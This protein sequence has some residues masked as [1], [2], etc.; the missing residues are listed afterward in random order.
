MIL[1]GSSSGLFG[2]LL[3]CP[4]YSS[5]VNVC[6]V[7]TNG[8]SNNEEL[9]NKPGLYYSLGHTMENKNVEFPIGQV[10]CSQ[11]SSV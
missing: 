4:P 7:L 6:F 3:T 5:T 9:V 10:P 11:L 2:D 1:K 8:I